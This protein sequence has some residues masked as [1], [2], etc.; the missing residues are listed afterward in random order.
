MYEEHFDIAEGITGV[1]FEHCKGEDASNH[2]MSKVAER[3]CGFWIPSEEY[4]TL[5]DLSDEE[6]NY[7]FYQHMI[8]YISQS[9]NTD[10]NS[11]LYD[12]LVNVGLLEK[13]ETEEKEVKNTE[14]MEAIMKH[15]AID[16]EGA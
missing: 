2:E 6:Y 12:W 1:I 7:S 11:Y 9:I 14:E 4:G 15:W 8:K 16:Q 3:I 10:A 5:T 13:V